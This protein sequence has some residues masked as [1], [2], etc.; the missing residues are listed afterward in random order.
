VNVTDLLSLI[1]SLPKFQLPVANIS[2]LHATHNLSDI[3]IPLVS[4]KGIHSAVKEQIK[5]ALTLGAILGKDILGNH[6]VG[7]QK[8]FSMPSLPSVNVSSMAVPLH[9]LLGAGM[10]VKGL[11]LSHLLAL[12][13]ATHSIQVP[14]LSLPTLNVSDVGVPLSALV[15]LK[16]KGLPLL[17]HLAGN[18]SLS[19]P[20]IN[21]TKPSFMHGNA[22]VGAI[23]LPALLGL[24]GA[25]LSMFHG[26]DTKIALPDILSLL[27]ANKSDIN[28]LAGLTKS[29]NMSDLPL[30]SLAALHKAFNVSGLPLSALVDGK[31]GALAALLGGMGNGT[32][33]AGPSIGINVVPGSIGM[34]NI[35]LNLTH[36]TLGLKPLALALNLTHPELAMRL[37][38]LNFS[39]PVPTVGMG[40]SALNLTLPIPELSAAMGNLSVTV[41]TASVSMP[42]VSVDKNGT[43]NGTTV[44]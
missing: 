10:A 34:K 15:G 29:F 13:N 11:P 30:G 4:L 16:F 41:P 23:P 27:H 38:S 18:A 35:G 26:N 28:L 7:L 25:F 19:L 6:T 14:K 43:G 44:R 40:S 8:N 21:I 12:V 17:A 33:A 9:A 1:H 37:A 3:Q 20:V 36:P 31:L 39:L 5:E 32:I 2:G 24:K 22:T 42:S